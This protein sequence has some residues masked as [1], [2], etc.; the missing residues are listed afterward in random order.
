MEKKELDDELLRQSRE[1]KKRKEQMRKRRQKE[2]IIKMVGCAA[3][4]AAIVGITTFATNKL[5]LK[6]GKKKPE[7]ESS[8]MAVTEKETESVN[9]LALQEAN[10]LAAGY[11]YDAAIEKLQAVNGYAQDAELTAAIAEYTSAKA[12]CVAVDV[13]SVPHIV[14]QSLLNEPAV[15]LNASVVGDNTASTLDFWRTTVDEFDG[16]VQ[17]MY[18]NGYVIVRM[19]DL[20]VES[21]DASGKVTFTRN[22]NLML[23]QGKK[24]VVIS[25]DNLNYC[26]AYEKA[27]FPD[28]LVLDANGDVK[29]HYVKTDGSEA[30]G[31]FDVV[32]RLN[33]FLEQH[34]DGAYHGARG[35]IGLSGY[36]GVFGY[37]T[38]TA[39][40]TRENLSTEQSAWLAAHAD[41]DW[42][43]E[44][45]QA[46]KIAEALKAS[47][48][49]FA[50]RTWGDVNVSESSL[51]SL[52]TD[53]EKWVNTV[54]NIVGETDTIVFSG[55]NDIGDWH[56]YTT[57]NAKFSFY[58]SKGYNFFC[59]VDSSVPFWVQIRESYVLQGRISMGGYVLERASQGQTNV[60][61]DLFDIKQVF[62]SD[63]TAAAASS[64][65]G[66]AAGQPE[67]GET[68]AGETQAGES[69]TQGTAL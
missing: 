22:E 19:R 44:V 2:K 17:Q 35:M 58:K 31:D 45:A 14:F 52:Q 40:K 61:N 57:D 34:P 13:D 3:V 51:E 27:G 50:S 1:I 30:V 5:G 69:E 54:Q 32:P 12:G 4:L 53:N 39:Y 21:K 33:T 25:V 65:G 24:A 67:T 11:D 20:V 60:V 55:G 41:F 62:N 56:D 26:H 16:I 38:D 66:S 10:L 8:S 68:Q 63:R 59:N 49:E 46:K 23:P 48:W 6:D 9:A 47:G 28:K 37:R 18:D 29:C 36:N 64:L 7:T 15:S 43:K 42:D